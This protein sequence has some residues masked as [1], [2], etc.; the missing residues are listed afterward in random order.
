L[1]FKKDGE[2]VPAE[3]LELMSEESVQTSK[4]ENVTLFDV[5]KSVESGITD[6]EIAS[7][8]ITQSDS[9]E[10]IMKVDGTAVFHNGLLA[11]YL[12]GM[13]TRGCMWITGQVK[14]GV[15]VLKLPNGGTASMEILGSSSKI[16][17]S[18]D[19]KN[20]VIIVNI[21]V[22]TNLTEIQ[23]KSDYT[24]NDDFISKLIK[25]QGQTVTAEAQ[26]AVDQVLKIYGADV[27][28]FGMKIFE[29]DPELWRKIGKNWGT[30]AQNTKVE[31]TTNSFMRHTGL[32]TKT[33]FATDS[34]IKSLKLF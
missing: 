7:V 17:V 8:A 9:G 19:D 4:I 12:D 14:G 1:T 29:D 30:D 22:G 20:P 26:A 13:Q 15:I 2:I 21:S 28:G 32:T 25:L 3:N 10:D 6:P 11:G 23:S 24:I 34:V 27:F 16:S 18:G 5:F 33:V 31:I